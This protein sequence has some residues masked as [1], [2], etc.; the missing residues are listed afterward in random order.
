M[1]VA[2]NL[3]ICSKNKLNY[4]GWNECILYNVCTTYAELKIMSCVNQ[5]LNFI[6]SFHALSYDIF[7]NTNS[8]FENKDG[9]E[10]GHDSVFGD[11]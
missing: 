3:Y 11:G 9:D 5:S 2:L 1:L 6:I 8:I 4:S 7:I 10:Y